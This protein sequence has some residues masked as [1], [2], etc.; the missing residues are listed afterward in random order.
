MRKL[1]IVLSLMV[2]LI[3][4]VMLSASVVSAVSN[5][6]PGDYATQPQESPPNGNASDNESIETVTP[7]VTEP[8][9]L[10]ASEIKSIEERRAELLA[11]GAIELVDER[12]EY[13]EVYITK[14]GER[15]ALIN[16]VPLYF[17]NQDGSYQRIDNSLIPNSEQSNSFIN[18]ANS[19]SIIFPESIEGESSITFKT[20]D[21]EEIQFNKTLK[22]QSLDKDNGQQEL[23]QAQASKGIV[24]QNTITYTDVYPDI[25]AEF[26]VSSSGIKQNYIINNPLAG[27]NGQTGAKLAFTE[28]IVLPEGWQFAVEGKVRISDFETDQNIVLL[29]AK[30]RPQ[31]FLAQPVAFDKS[32]EMMDPQM[33]AMVSLVYRVEYINKSTISISILIPVDWLNQPE[34]LYPVT[35]DP[36][37]YVYESYS[38][39]DG[40]Q[41]SSSGMYTTY[42][43]LITGS[44]ANY[45][46]YITYMMWRGI[47]IPRYSTINNVY[48]YFTPYSSSSTVCSWDFYFENADSAL[49]CSSQLPSSR[50]YVTSGNYWSNYSTPWT[51]GTTIAWDLSIGSGAGLQ[52]VVNRSGWNPGNNIGMK[53]AARNSSS[54]YRLVRSIN[55]SQASAPYL[56]IVYTAPTPPPPPTNVSATD[57]TYTDRVRISWTASS[58]A[59]G[60]KVFRNT[61]NNS[62]TASQIGTISASPYDDYTAAIGTTYYYWV[63]AYNGAGDSGFSSYNTGWRAV[64]PPTSVSAT[65]GTYSDRVRITWTA[66]TG[67]S[68]YYIYRNTVNN[69]STATQIGTSAASPYD[70]TSAAIGTTYYYWVK[71]YVSQGASG[72]SNVDTGWRAPAAPTNVVATDGTYT[73]KVQITW[74]ASTG[75]SGYYIY[76]NTVNNSSTATQIGTIS[77][78]PYNDTSAAVGITYYYWVKAYVSQG[79]S[80]FSNVDTGWRAPAAPTNV[81][82]TDG[83]YTDKVQITWTASS[84]ALGYYV[85]R[86]TVNN[87]STATQIGT[88]SA[89]PYNDTSA[90]VGVTYYFW[91]KAYVSQGASGFSNVDTGWRAPAAPTNV[92]ATDG[93]Y[94]DKVRITWTASSGAIGYKVFRNY[95]NDSGTAIQIGNSGASPFDDTSAAGDTIYYYWV[96]AY[97]SQGDSG[98]SNSDTGWR[99]VPAPTNVIAS[100]GVYTDKIRISWTASSGA[101]GYEIFRNTIN[102]SGTANELWSVLDTYWDDTSATPGVTY[103][104]WVKAYGPYTTSP[105]SNPDTGWRQLPPPT[106]VSATKG[107]FDRIEVDWENTAG[108][109]GYRIYR[110]TVDE[111]PVDYLAYSS[112]SDYTDTQVAVDTRYWYWIQ[113]IR[114]DGGLIIGPCSITTPGVG[115]PA[116]VG[117]RMDA[118]NPPGFQLS[119]GT[120]T[121]VY[122]KALVEMMLD[123]GLFLGW[124]FYDFDLSATIT[125]D[126]DEVGVG[127]SQLALLNGDADPDT[128]QFAVTHISDY[129]GETSEYFGFFLQYITNTPL[130]YSLDWYCEDEDEA[131]IIE[132]FFEYYDDSWLSSCEIHYFMPGEGLKS[133]SLPSLPEDSQSVWNKLSA[134]EAS[135]LVGYEVANPDS[136]PGSFTHHQ[137]SAVKTANKTGP[138]VIM[139]QWTDGE[140]QITLIQDPDCTGIING[141]KSVI[142]GI[143]GERGYLETSGK[144]PPVV[145]YYWKVGNMGY[146]LFA[147]LTDSLDQ[148]TV[149]K[150]I[151]DTLK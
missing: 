64:S 151:T 122:H 22:I 131:I 44:N 84:G 119:V 124:W 97:V 110:N 140:S 39:D 53:W 98:F 32:W 123:N 78:S 65:D 94:T 38:G 10:P 135:G 101:I 28:E 48:F 33:E 144:A 137:I 150:I 62:G 116:S 50:S 96:K 109:T 136:I 41:W 87:S 52:Q 113:P 23:Y 128:S 2:I 59:T 37:F 63:K 143:T 67:A 56:Q 106:D 61:V 18:K 93:A 79:A 17:N 57:G 46:Y 3:M 90:A 88:I 35:I 72:F 111:I 92:I 81:V 91:V 125:V 42:Q 80:G 132:Q 6:T 102:D 27:L 105:F 77:A 86:N 8:I 129:F 40:Y 58:G 104:Y 75:A 51:A 5:E 71:A 103:Y 16:A 133:D 146:V 43:W 66:S 141:E 4:A 138:T 29:D 24:A 20:G 13:A 117:F 69:S 74:T 85:Y 99:A 70:D 147:T 114:E 83:T 108:A 1:T 121:Y 54:S 60:Y 134:N 95:Y 31:G 14:E 11:N 126:T 130:Y 148:S 30:G 73:D 120:D 49:P 55:Y 25:N 149:E 127:V 26:A 9:V 19:F 145:Q 76:R 45:P 118:N 34:R 7:I 47:S 89:S 21:G 36:S 107:Y 12:T 15:I 82:A 100:D 68:G 142:N 112:T 139:Q 115:C